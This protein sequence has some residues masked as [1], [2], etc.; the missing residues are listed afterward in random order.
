MHNNYFPQIDTKMKT[1][2]EG[3]GYLSS[4]VTLEEIKSA[5]YLIND[6]KSPGPDGFSA[7]IYK[8]HWDVPFNSS[9]SH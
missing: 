9:G 4:H 2:A 6:A 5:L 7:K 3:Q 8:L 1:N